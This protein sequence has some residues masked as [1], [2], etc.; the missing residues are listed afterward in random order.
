MESFDKN[1]SVRLDADLIKRGKEAAKKRGLRL[2]GLIRLL[3]VDYL[4]GEG[5]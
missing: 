3:L 4:K 1:F 5:R 2:G